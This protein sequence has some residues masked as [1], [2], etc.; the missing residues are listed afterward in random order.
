M[1]ASVYVPY[2]VL[3][4]EI[5]ILS[6]QLF[7]TLPVVFILFKHYITPKHP[8]ILRLFL[9]YLIVFACVASANSLYLI[10]FWSPTQN[11]YHLP[12]LYSLGYCQWAVLFPCH[13][14][15]FFIGLE[16]CLVLIMKF[17]YTERLKTFNG[18][19][20]IFVVILYGTVITWYEKLPILPPP[21][22]TI[23]NCRIYDC[24]LDSQPI[25]HMR[26]LTY[27]LVSM[28]LGCG[29]L[30]FFLL[31]IIFRKHKKTDSYLFRG[32]IIT[33]ITTGF[34]GWFPKLITA[35]SYLVWILELKKIYQ[36]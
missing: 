2:I 29:V 3:G 7:I 28:N 5:F 13:I 12:L 10:I 26:T 17:S 15:E 19:F 30:L 4:Q 36:L 27:V 18:I 22:D 20:A 34:L 24:I 33:I 9:I 1:P 25:V 21:S 23:I 14:I 11:L 6:S 32:A 31:K 8:L 16:R 35:L